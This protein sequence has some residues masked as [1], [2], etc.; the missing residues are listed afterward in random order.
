MDVGGQSRTFVL[1]AAEPIENVVGVRRRI[2]KYKLLIRTARIGSAMLA[3][4]RK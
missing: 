2:N 1:H 3:E 4:Y